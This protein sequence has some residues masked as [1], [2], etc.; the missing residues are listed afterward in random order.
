[1]VACY[2]I[3]YSNFLIFNTGFF[4]D[5]PSNSLKYYIQRRYMFYVGSSGGGFFSF[6]YEFGI[7]NTNILSIL[8]IVV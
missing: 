6:S 5:W 8:K 7:Q 1:M 3:Y 4:N 2:R